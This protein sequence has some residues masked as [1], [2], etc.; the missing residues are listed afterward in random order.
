MSGLGSTRC[1]GMEFRWGERTY[2]MGVINATPDSF[3][4]DGIGDNVDMALALSPRVLMS[5]M[6]VLNQLAPRP[7]LY[8]LPRNCAEY[9]R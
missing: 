3:S 1:R 4:G 8:P 5:L 9:F 7:G 6:L 2:I